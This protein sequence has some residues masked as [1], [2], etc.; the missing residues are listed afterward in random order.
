ME[1]VRKYQLS[2]TIYI[3]VYIYNGTPPPFIYKKENVIV[4]QLF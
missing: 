4:I 3:L 1:E 2:A